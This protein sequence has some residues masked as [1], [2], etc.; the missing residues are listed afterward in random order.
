MELYKKYRPKSFKTVI[1]Q[2]HATK[3]LEKMVE[4]NKVPHTLLFSGSSGNG[5]TTLARILSKQL[6]CSKYDLNEINCADFRGIDMVRDIRDQMCLS[7]LG[8]R[9][10]VWIIDESHKLS[11]DAQNAFLKILEDTPEHVYFMLATTHPEKL[12]NTIRTRCTEI[13]IKDLTGQH[14]QRLLKRICKK[15]GL[16]IS[17]DVEERI[18]EQCEGSARKALVLLDQV[19]NLEDEQERIDSIKSSTVET[20]SISIAKL[21]MNKNTKWATVASALKNCTPENVEQIRWS[22]LGY[23]GKVMLGGGS[24]A[25]RAFIIVDFFKDPFYDSKVAG[26]THA[27]YSVVHCEDV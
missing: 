7:P 22:V 5:K 19:A 2:E 1:G 6:N 26:L 27:C 25:A 18:L 21:L 20:Q 10:K 24:A 4:N 8:G 12:L 9:C 3:L 14:I 15:E 16:T 13:K 17:D 11:A 23:A